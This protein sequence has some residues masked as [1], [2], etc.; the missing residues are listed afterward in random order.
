MKR[1]SRTVDQSD[2]VDALTQR[3]L[4]LVHLLVDTRSELMD[5]AV[6]S[7]LQVL[8]TILED[9]RT[10]ICGQRYQHQMGII[11]IHT[12]NC[13]A[14]DIDRPNRLVWDLGPGPQVSWRQVV[15]AAKL[16]RDV[17]NTLGLRSWVKTTGGRT[18]RRRPPEAPANRRR[19][20][21]L[22]ARRQRGH[23]EDRTAVLHDSVRELDETP[24]RWTLLT[25]PRRVRHLRADP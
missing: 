24:D 2:Q 8:Q 19:M 23:R 1:E 18:A 16:V 5:L 20:P 22:L 7:G 9:D 14:D 11:E 10:A 15:K 13:T 12:W 4:P 6:A 17:L 21:R 25:V 3:H